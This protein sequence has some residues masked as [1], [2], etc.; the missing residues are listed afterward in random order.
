LNIQEKFWSAISRG[1]GEAHLLMKEHPKT[2]FSQYILKAAVKNLEYDAQSTGSRA[3]YVAEIVKLSPQK[4]KL[5]KDILKAL[6][7]KNS[8]TWALVQLFDI[9][10]IFAKEG[11]EQAREAIYKRYPIYKIPDSDWCGESAILDLDGIEGFKFIAE[12]KGKAILENPEIWEDD[13]NLTYFQEKNPL[14]KVYDELKKASESN[15]YIK[16]YL[17]SLQEDRERNEKWV[18][19]KKQSAYISVNNIIETNNISRY[20]RIPSPLA[21]KLNEKEIEVLAN[22]FL[23]ETNEAKQVIYLSIFERTKF[24]FDYHPIF[25]IAKRKNT[26]KNR[27]VGF[28]NTALGFFT[29]KEIRD[30]AISKLKKTKEPYLYDTLLINNYKKGDYKLLKTLVEKAKNTDDAHSL[31]WS[32]VEIYEKNRTKECKEPLEALY[33]KLNCGR[34]RYDIIKI[35]LDNKVLS[36]KIR[37]EAK[38]DSFQETRELVK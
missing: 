21:L 29:A 11:N 30:F 19:P 10:A 6:A 18:A 2:D 32:Y 14:I 8:D 9:A 33:D 7:K 16:K 15:T 22:R 4:D 23:K 24:P 5:V 35:L 28:A 38:F 1:T 37:E 26:K 36:E 3:N 12:A 17:D 25:E 31:V 13:S 34:H 27:L 20:T